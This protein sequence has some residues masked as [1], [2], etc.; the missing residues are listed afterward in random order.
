MSNLF[1]VRNHLQSIMTALDNHEHGRMPLS[2]FEEVF[3]SKVETVRDLIQAEQ[4]G[5][6]RKE[7]V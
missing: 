3:E 6:E 5:C 7:A 2:Y 1:K 4:R